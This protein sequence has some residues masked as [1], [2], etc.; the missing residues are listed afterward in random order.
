MTLTT[1]I[2]L[3]TKN[4]SVEKT[5]SPIFT[6]RGACLSPIGRKTPETGSTTQSRE[7]VISKNDG[8]RPLSLRE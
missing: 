1:A 2:S 3:R 8:K 5:L 6:N 7:S 4:L